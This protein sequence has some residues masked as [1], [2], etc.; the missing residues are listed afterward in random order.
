[1]Q[2]PRRQY[3][4]GNIGLRAGRERQFGAVRITVKKGEYR[5]QP[6]SY[7]D[8]G[9]QGEADRGP[10]HDDGQGDSIFRR[11]HR[12]GE[13]AQNRTDGHHHREDDRQQ[14]NQRPAKE[15]AP[16]SDRHHRQQMVE[17]QKRM[18]ES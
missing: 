10:Q 1:M 2:Q 12:H 15:R 17:P 14:I 16:D 6:H 8:P 4:A 5:D 9:A 11:R 13:Y 3:K 7:E 18:R